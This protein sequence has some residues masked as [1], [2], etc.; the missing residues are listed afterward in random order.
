MVGIAT[1]EPSITRRRI[2]NLVMQ[3]STNSS[4]CAKKDPLVRSQVFHAQVIEF[5]LF[6]AVTSVAKCIAV[7]NSA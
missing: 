4:D 7:H 2:A 5:T 1:G 6:F 3:P